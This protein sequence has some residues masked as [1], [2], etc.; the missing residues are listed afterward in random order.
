MTFPPG[1]NQSSTIPTVSEADLYFARDNAVAVAKIRAWC[2]GTEAGTRASMAH[3]QS[4]SARRACE[5]RLAA[6]EAVRAL[7]PPADDPSP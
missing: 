7:L 4:A 2:D 1:W 3:T 5:V 6:V